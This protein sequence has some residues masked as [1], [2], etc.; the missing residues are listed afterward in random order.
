MVEES[1]TFC[2]ICD[3]CHYTWRRVDV[4]SKSEKSFSAM[5]RRNDQENNR[6]V[7][8]YPL[9]FS[10]TLACNDR[11]PFNSPEN[12]RCQNNCLFIK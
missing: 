3:I 10:L 9:G 2:V 1:L 5:G 6:Q 11:K 7:L 12:R 8:I 4:K